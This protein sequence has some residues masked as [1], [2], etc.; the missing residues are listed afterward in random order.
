MMLLPPKAQPGD[1]VAILSPSLAAPGFAP[2][3]HEQAM[4][5][6]EADSSGPG[7]RHR[8]GRG[9]DVLQR[10]GPAAYP[11][12]CPLRARRGFL[13]ALWGASA[14]LDPRGEFAMGRGP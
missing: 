13:G 11:G 6:L 10:P 3:V 14:P 9:R 8:L 12:D 7:L 2:A 1:R 5:R 4:A